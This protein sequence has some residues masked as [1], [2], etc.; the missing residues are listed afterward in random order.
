M[1]LN[2][3]QRTLHS[4]RDHTQSRPL[5]QQRRRR[6][7]RQHLTAPCQAN[8]LSQLFQR[9]SKDTQESDGRLVERPVYKPS[10]MIEL[11]PGVKISPMGLGTWAW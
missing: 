2:S 11:A 4:Q 3:G 5:R 10:E 1:Q 7:G 9:G 8:F 6:P